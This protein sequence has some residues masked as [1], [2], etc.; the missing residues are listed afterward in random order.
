VRNKKRSIFLKLSLVITI[1]GI[2]I[3]CA[4]IQFIR[5]HFGSKVNEQL[6]SSVENYYRYIAKDLGNPP[7]TLLAKAIADKYFIAIR[8][9]SDPAGRNWQY[10]NADG[11][12]PKE[13]RHLLKFIA[14]FWRDDPLAI[15]NTD[16]SRFIFSAD[17]HRIINPNPL[18]LLLFLSALIIILSVSYLVIRNILKPVKQL[19]LG[20]E[21]VAKG[22]L[23]Y[24][25][26]VMNNDELT[27][28][29]RSFNEMTKRIKEMIEARNRLLLDVS[30]EL[31]SPITRIKI[32][33]L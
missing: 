26:P 16:G 2:L 33:L 13:I 12:L 1:T 9:E 17:F 15:T 20:V 23:E 11:E 7:D 19:S 32:A 31:R 21:E 14:G 10:G 28:L 25:V 8:Y 6:S 4:F 3:G 5:F 22:N 27:L 29:S 24:K 30:H 18:E